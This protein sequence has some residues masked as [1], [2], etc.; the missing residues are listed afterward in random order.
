MTVTDILIEPGNDEDLPFLRE[1]LF[2]A[3]YWN[4]TELETEKGLVEPE[5]GKILHGWGRSGDT[6]YVAVYDGDRLGAVWYRFWTQ[7]HHSYGFVDSQTPEI[8][9]G[10]A[11]P[12]RYRGIGSA[13]MSTIINHARDS[14]V[15]S[16]SLSV[17]PINKPALRLYQSCGFVRVNEIV[18]AWTMVKHF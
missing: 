13:L 8:G 3:A 4:G 10:V 11:Q 7:Q 17:E 5:I 9:I 16:L 12:Y 15:P 2:E 1:M 6:S 18:G 14:G